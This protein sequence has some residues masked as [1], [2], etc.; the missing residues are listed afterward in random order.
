MQQKEVFMQIYDNGWTWIHHFT[1]ESNWQSA[2]WAAADESRPKRPKTLT[3][4]GKVLVSVFWDVQSIL[5]LD[6]LVKGRTISSEYYIAI[7]VPLKEKIAKK[8]AANE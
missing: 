7:L 2:E 4:T 3:S 6:Y 1:L 5:F 8:T